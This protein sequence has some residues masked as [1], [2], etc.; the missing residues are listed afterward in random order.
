MAFLKF[1]IHQQR[2]INEKLNIEKRRKSQGRI[3]TC[4]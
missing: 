1:K 4:G 3:S 2:K